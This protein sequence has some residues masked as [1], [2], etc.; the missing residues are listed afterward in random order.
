MGNLSLDLGFGEVDYGQHQTIVHCGAMAQIEDKMT[1][2]GTSNP[3][4]RCDLDAG[5]P[6]R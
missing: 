1:E 3:T 6:I 4:S 5:K 2:D